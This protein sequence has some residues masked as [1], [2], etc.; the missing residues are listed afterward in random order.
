MLWTAKKGSRGSDNM[1]GHWLDH[2]DDPE[3]VALGIDNPI[4]YYVT[5]RQLQTNWP[6]TAKVG[7]RIADKPNIFGEQPLEQVVMDLANGGF[8]VKVLTGQQAGT[9]KTFFVA[10]GGP[11]DWTQYFTNQH[12]TTIL[13]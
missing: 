10:E 4:D 5:A 7:T 9:L 13:Q 12:C 1:L 2:K 11:A 3:L 8:S 6:S